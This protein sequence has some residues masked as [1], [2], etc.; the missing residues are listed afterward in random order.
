VRRADA[1]TRDRFWQQP[2]ATAWKLERLMDVTVKGFE[3]TKVAVTPDEKVKFPW[4][5]EF[6]MQPTQVKRDY[7]APYLTLAAPTATVSLPAGYVVLPGHDEAVQN[8]LA[9]GLA[10]E[11]LGRACK[12]NAERFAL[13]K[14]E[15]ATSLY[16]GHVAVTLTGRYEQAEV[17]LPA[18]S[19]FVDLRQP[20]ARL[21]PVLLEP[22][23]G[24][25][26][27]AWGFFNRALVRQWSTEPGVYP[28]LRLD[29]RPPVPLVVM[30]AMQASLPPR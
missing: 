8:L 18:G 2:F 11:Q 15:T 27:A 10:V 23:S 3:H 20:L 13:Q 14:V 7:T 1:E 22:T 16:Q 4:L 30:S 28:V 17:E 21:V 25:S 9:H 26:L 12:V 29:T 5:G 6:R 24:D 19:V